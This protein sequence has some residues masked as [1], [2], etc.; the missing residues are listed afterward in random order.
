MNSLFL[1]NNVLINIPIYDHLYYLVIPPQKEVSI[2]I[3]EGRN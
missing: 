3:Y 1:I 2:S